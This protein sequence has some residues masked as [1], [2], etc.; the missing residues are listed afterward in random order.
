[1]STEVKCIKRKCLNNKNGVCTAQLIEYEGLC[2][3]YIT[4]DHAHKSNCGLC[5]RSH[6]RFK[7]N[8]RDVLR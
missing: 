1:M 3:T 8:G 6:G 7:R 5:T 2:Q 4:H